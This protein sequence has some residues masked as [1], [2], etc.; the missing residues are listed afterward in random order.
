MPIRSWPWKTKKTH[1]VRELTRLIFVE[2][3]TASVKR[4]VTPA[5]HNEVWIAC[6]HD[7]PGLFISMPITFIDVDIH[8]LDARAPWEGP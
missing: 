8:P 1:A 2:G 5:T 4:A 7:I 6:N 3:Q